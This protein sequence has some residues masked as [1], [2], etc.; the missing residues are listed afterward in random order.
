MSHLAILRAVQQRNQLKRNGSL[1]EF[2]YKRKPRKV[3]GATCLSITHSVSNT[4]SKYERG[5]NKECFC[6]S[7]IGIQRLEWPG[8]FPPWETELG[9]EKMVNDKRCHS[10]LNHR[11]QFSGIYRRRLNP[12]VLDKDFQEYGMPIRRNESTQ[13]PRY[14][15]QATTLRTSQKWS[16][17][18]R[19]S[20]ST[21]ALRF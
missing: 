13:E 18:L 19:Q 7:T 17:T 6:C 10:R 3:R 20:S 2:E 14:R 21:P 5:C 15:T 12:N 16:S 11:R 9:I 1:P 8:E 4:A